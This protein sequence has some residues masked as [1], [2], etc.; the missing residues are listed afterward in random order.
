MLAQYE[1]VKSCGHVEVEQI[2]GSNTRGQRDREAKKRAKKPCASCNQATQQQLNARAADV[3]T[4]AG[5]PELAGSPAQVASAQTIR[6]DGLAALVDEA[7]RQA[8]RAQAAGWTPTQ[9][10]ALAS[11]LV[12]VWERAVLRQTAAA[13][14]IE[15]KRRLVAAAGEVLTPEDRA[16][17]K[18]GV[19]AI[20]AGLSDEAASHTRASDEGEVSRMTLEQADLRERLVDA[21]RE[22]GERAADAERAR[23]AAIAEIGELLRR[24]RTNGD[25]VG[26]T[27]AEHITNLSR[28]TLTK[29]RTDTSAWSDMMG[30]ARRALAVGDDHGDETAL[31]ARLP[32]LAGWHRATDYLQRRHVEAYWAARGGFD[33]WSTT[34]DPGQAPG[35][36]A[37]RAEYDHALSA[38]AAGEPSYLQRLHRHAGQ[39]NHT[40]TAPSA[41]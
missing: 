23:A 12:R 35:L 41:M 7:Q 36:P 1:I 16:E 33:P 6:A 3:A 26:I 21:L 17:H 15:H 4:A 30:I 25:L 22:A 34:D 32:Y 18:A 20:V 29:A 2:Y 5:W 8:E 10:D 27:Y 11:L 28:P 31:H 37:L 24:D 9:A 38:Y 40:A 14:W 39:N 19:D 13:W